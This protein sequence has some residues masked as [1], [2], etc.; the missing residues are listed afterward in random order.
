MSS[1]NS[2]KCEFLYL[3]SPLNK[4][5]PSELTQAFKMQ[6]LIHNIH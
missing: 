5:V 6:I 4:F 2:F 1:Q 3:S